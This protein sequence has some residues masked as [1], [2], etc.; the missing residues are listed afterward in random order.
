MQP[1]HIL[2]GTESG[3][4]E[5]L[6]KRAGDAVRDAGFEAVVVDMTDFEPRSIADTTTVLVIT[7]TFGNGDPPFN[8]EKLHAFLMKDCKPLPMLRFSVL[9]LG[10]TTYDH[11]AQC[12][13]DFDRR[14]GELGA[15]RLAPRVDCD[16]D[17]E[18]PYEKWLE[19]VLAELPKL[20]FAKAPPAPA[21]TPRLESDE[22]IG[23][24]RRPLTAQVLQNENLNRPGST[25]ETRHL[26]LGWQEPDFAYELGDSIGIFADNGTARVDA[27]L[28][29]TGLDGA[30]EVA[31][32][33]SRMPLGIALQTKLDV[34]HIDARLLTKLGLSSDA[35]Q[36]SKMIETHHVVDALRMTERRIGAQELVEVLRP[37]AP[38][39]YSIASS[40]HV[41]P[42][43]AY[44]LVDVIRYTLHGDARAGVFSEQVAERL[45]VGDEV[46]IYRHP[47]PHFRLCDGSTPIVMIGPGTGVAPFRGFVEERIRSGATGRSWLFFGARHRATDF[48]YETELLA[49][50]KAAKLELSLA[51]S[52]DQDDKVYV[53]HLMRAEGR[54]LYGLIE[55]GAVIYVCGSAKGMAPGVHRA[56]I[57]ILMVEGGLD[58]EQ[59]TERLAQMERE[60]RYQ[61]DVY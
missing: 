26:V 17:Y 40:P 28:E 10:D 20:D 56:L 51:F 45:T 58:R 60:R 24:R 4:A 2:F 39:L 38:R 1:I 57:E 29:A 22:P 36:T 59:A 53:Q 25:R 16:V 37:L 54:A 33:S 34:A 6:A 55:E 41:H 42:G 14:L 32:A 11:F 52:R 18:E 50:H 31:L 35:K 48:F 8:A 21:S 5:A 3:N 43:Q 44:L 9:A 7:S 30:T 27:L 23:S 12:G 49:W 13:K 46:P 15:T 47:A 19:Q 61:R